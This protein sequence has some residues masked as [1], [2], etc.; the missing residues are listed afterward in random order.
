MG[1]PLEGV[2]KTKNEEQN[3]RQV[4]E[5][6]SF[7]YTRTFLLKYRKLHKETKI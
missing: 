3:Y 4:Q 7:L 6:S 5:A 1:Y 2:Y